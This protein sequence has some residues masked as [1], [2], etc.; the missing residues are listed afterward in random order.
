MI[1]AIEKALDDL[2]SPIQHT[3]VATL[4]LSIQARRDNG[5]RTR[6]TDAVKEGIRIETFVSNHR[7]CAQMLNQLMGTRDV[8]VLLQ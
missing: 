1:D 4:R 5:H 8:R 3:A 7:T 6:S 2:A